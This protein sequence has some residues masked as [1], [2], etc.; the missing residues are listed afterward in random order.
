MCHMNSK[1]T[2]FGAKKVMQSNNALMFDLLVIPSREGASNHK[3]GSELGKII[4]NLP[5][6]QIN[7]PFLE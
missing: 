4:V 7:D 1:P 5:G 3:F 2:V 6:G